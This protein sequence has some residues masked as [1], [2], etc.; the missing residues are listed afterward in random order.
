MEKDSKRLWVTEV[1]EYDVNKMLCAK[2]IEV[3]SLELRE[4]ENTRKQALETLRDWIMKNPKIDN[5]R[6]GLF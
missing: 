3:A 1:D 2:T 4:T 6:L 5:C